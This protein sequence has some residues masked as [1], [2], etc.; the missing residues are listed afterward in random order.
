MPLEEGRPSIR[1]FQRE[2]WMLCSDKVVAVP[3]P[4][5]PAGEALN[6]RGSLRG[7][8]VLDGADP[9]LSPL[10]CAS[11][12]PGQGL[13]LDCWIRPAGHGKEKVYGSI[14]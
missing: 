11:V 5:D 10:A 7:R 14:P 2:F 1:A 12:L 8:K 13:Y 9:G 4:A 6:L 3:A